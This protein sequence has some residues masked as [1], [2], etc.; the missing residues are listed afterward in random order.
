MY[1]LNNHFSIQPSSVAPIEDNW[2]DEIE[3]SQ[4]VIEYHK[5]SLPASAIFLVDSITK[6]EQFLDTGLQVLIMVQ[7]S[8]LIIRTLCDKN[9]VYQKCK[10]CLGCRVFLIFANK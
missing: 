2:D 6:F 7:I 10:F 4:E 8:F 5:M 3:Q 1:Y 9:R